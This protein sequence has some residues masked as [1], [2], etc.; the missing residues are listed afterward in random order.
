MSAGVRGVGATGDDGDDGG[1]AGRCKAKSKN[2]T[3][4]CGENTSKMQVFFSS[5]HSAK[6]TALLNF[7]ESGTRGAL[8]AVRRGQ[9]RQPLSPCFKEG[10]SR[11]KAERPIR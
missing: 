3:Q 4:R 7:V 11:I 8:G 9:S 10:L 1:G 6:K 5:L 2:P